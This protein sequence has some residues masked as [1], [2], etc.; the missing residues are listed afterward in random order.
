MKENNIR[1]SEK[2]KRRQ[3]IVSSLCGKKILSMKKLLVICLFLGSLSVTAQQDP[4]F[5][6]YMFNKLVVNPA[7]AG[8][9][10]MT[11]IELLD[12]YQWAG[13]EGAPKTLTLSAHTVTNNNKVGLGVYVYRDE[14]GP[15]IDQGLMATY[16]YRIET[17]KG[18]FSMG[19]QGGIKYFNYDWDMIHTQYPDNSYL[20]QETQLVTPDFNLGFYYQTNRFFAGLS[21]K[22]LLEN[23]FGSGE[24]NGNTNFSRLSRHFY[25]MSGMAVPLNDK[26]VFRP[27][28]L[29]KYARNAPVQTDFNASILFRDIFWVGMSYRFNQAVTFLTEFRITKTLRLGYSFDLYINDLQLHNKGSHEI[30]LALDFAKKSRMKT[31]RYF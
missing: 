2:Q 16:A 18:W 5:T 21:S 31:P 22:H 14:I 12:R 24:I 4:L 19:I 9:Q 27:S 17:R 10:G 23:E 11:T 7:Y 1:F 20:P 13:I 3:N 15:T 8:S 26:M 29:V 6:Q 28:I 30:R 25:A